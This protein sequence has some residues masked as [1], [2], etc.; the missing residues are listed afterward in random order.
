M[1]T[2]PGS[3]PDKTG[4]YFSMNRYWPRRDSVLTALRYLLLEGF[5]GGAR[6]LELGCGGGEGAVFVSRWAES[7]IGVDHEPHWVDSGVE[8]PQNVS[9]RVADACCLGE[10]WEGTFD[11]VIAYEVIEHV[12]D[13]K[14]MLSEV[15]RT[16]KKD[17]VALVST[18]NFT[19]HSKRPGGKRAPLF[20]YHRREFSAEEF[21]DLL[22]STG[23]PYRAFGLSQLTSAEEGGQ[24]VCCACGEKV[25]NVKVGS[26]FPEVSI[27][28][29]TRLKRPI[30]LQYSQGMLAILNAS[31]RKAPGPKARRRSSL[32][33]LDAALLSLAWMLERRN[34][35]VAEL[36]AVVSNRDS[37]LGELETVV[38]ARLED[39]RALK[40]ALAAKDERINRADETISGLQDRLH[41]LGGP[42]PPAGNDPAQTDSEVHE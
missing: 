7:Y 10:E 4:E 6:V 33:H 36:Q 38:D 8:C 35:H 28:S 32:S 42:A 12:D 29:V 19:L 14:A 41:G 37:H 21:E 23:R 11:V 31:P 34:Q 20:E 18:P 24:S 5:V 40:K 17:G 2:Q 16:L 30:P 13:A 25:L 15:L 27:E 26:S 1:K 9:F 39:I 3:D 22:R